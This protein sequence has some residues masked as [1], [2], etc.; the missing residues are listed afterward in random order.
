[1]STSLYVVFVY[2]IE[3]DVQDTVHKLVG[4]DG[5]CMG[6]VS[7]RVYVSILGMFDDYVSEVNPQPQFY[8]HAVEE[9]MALRSRIVDEDY[10]DGLDAVL[11]DMASC[12]TPTFVQFDFW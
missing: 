7:I 6:V 9:L 1:M 4:Y 11:S 5:D 2:H 10:R 12:P 8:A 3:G